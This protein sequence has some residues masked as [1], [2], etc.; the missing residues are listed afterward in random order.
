MAL[1]R[2]RK[3]IILLAMG[4]L[5]LC[6]LLR[7]GQ[8]RLMFF[9]SAQIKATPAAVQLSDEEVWL[10]VARGQ[11]QGWWIPARAQTAPVVLYLHG[12][13]SNLGDLVNRAARLHNMGAAI[14][15]IDYRGYGRSWGVFP[16]EASVYEDAEA[17]W[18]YLTQTRQIAAQQIVLYGESIGGAVAVEIAS[19]HPD[20]GGIIVESSFTSMRAMVTRSI[21]EFL[22][23]IDWILTQQFDSLT[24]VRSLQVPILLIH[25]TDDRTIPATMSQTLFAAA[26]E[27]KR[28]LLIPNA[29]HDNVPQIGGALYLQEVEAFI[30]Q[31]TESA[32]EYAMMGC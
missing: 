17:A 13:G 25:G 29:N 20:A 27:P 28:L 16:S 32:T 5:L 8:T 30:W 23:P 6:L 10:P 11:V 21:P 19:R 7:W 3:A 24:K 1:K 12:N 9:P 4:Y 22:L 2:V 15:L 26:P 31:V 14:F 18:Q